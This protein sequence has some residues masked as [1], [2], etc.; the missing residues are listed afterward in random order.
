MGVFILPFFLCHLPKEN[1]GI[2][3][4][5]KVIFNTSAPLTLFAGA[6]KVAL[7]TIASLLVFKNKLSLLSLVEPYRST[8]N[9]LNNTSA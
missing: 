3:L 6:P 9:R 2:V 8:K 7:Q 5:A 4:S 1:L